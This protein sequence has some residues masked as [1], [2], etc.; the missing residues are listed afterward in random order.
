MKRLFT[1]LILSG[2]TLP[3]WAQG[4]L[5]EDP[6]IFYRNEIS[7][8]LL[9]N[10]NGA[11]ASVRYGKRINARNKQIFEADLIGIKHPKEV[12]VSHPY[13]PSKS[14]VYG[15][16]NGF[17][18]LRAGYGRQREM[19]RKIDKGGIAIRGYFSL[20]PSLG[21]IKP[22]YYEVLRPTGGIY[23]NTLSEEKFDKSIH[24]TQIYGR[25]SFFRGV[26]EIML[27]PG[28]YARIGVS[29]EYSRK[30]IS[31]HALEGGLAIDAFV[32]K[33]PVMATEKKDFFFFSLFV[34]YRFGKILDATA[35][36]NFERLPPAF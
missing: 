26:N 15:K 1:I 33:I 30:D 23:E 16:E 31:L 20:G 14:F 19:F 12:R 10:S 6:G 35:R 5:S 34:S 21:M 25:A 8:G 28:A 7:V 22:I 27:A 13:N 29:F 24:Q 36:G 18:V 32:R 2:L 3:S 17:Y 11:G 9:L 4:E